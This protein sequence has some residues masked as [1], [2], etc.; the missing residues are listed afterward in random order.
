MSI[1]TSE[2]K[3]VSLAEAAAIVQDGMTIAVGGGLSWREPVAFLRELIRQGRRDLH[4]VGTAQ[5]WTWICFVAQA[6]SVWWRNPMLDLNR[7]SAWRLT[8]GVSARKASR[9]C[10]IPAA[11]RLFNN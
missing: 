9:K 8:S 4:V 7:I 6:L 2:Q 10:T 11:I 3:Q 5:A 1:F